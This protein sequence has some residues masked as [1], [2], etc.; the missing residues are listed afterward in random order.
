MVDNHA[1][2]MDGAAL[3][4]VPE[5]GVDVMSFITGKGAM[6]EDLA[7]I[8]VKPVTKE[9]RTPQ[10]QATQA[11]AKTKTPGREQQFFSIEGK[12]LPPG[13]SPELAAAARLV[14]EG[15]M[16]AAEFDEMV[17]QYKP[18]RPYEAPLKP[19]TRAEMVDALS[20]EKKDKVNPDIPEGT[21]VGLRLDIPAFNRKGF[22]VVTIH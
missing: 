3:F 12:K 6:S 21:R 19:A 16:T 8:K 13:R 5:A 20:S 11:E 1:K 22:Y 9:V 14:K 18:I 15:K 17:N 4:I 10:R 2:Q 7:R